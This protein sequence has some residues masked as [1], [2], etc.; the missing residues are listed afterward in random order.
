[1][2]SLPVKE[3]KSKDS[4]KDENKTDNEKEKEEQKGETKM[5]TEEGTVSEN[6]T[7]KKTKEKMEEKTT[8]EEEIK[9][10][11]EEEEEPPRILNG[12]MPDQISTLVR[13]GVYL[14]GLPVDPDA[15]HALLRLVLRLTRE[16][17]HAMTFAELGGV[18]LLLSLTQV[19]TFQ[20]FTSLVT[21]IIRH[22]LEDSSTMRMTLQK[23]SGKFKQ[24]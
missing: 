13:C 23:V 3:D 14:I 20:G 6:N 8:K 4:H 2:L 10:T 15:L 7:T 17:Q 24:T 9:E 1:M 21:L 16:H 12:L 11:K 22:I 18:K 5:D 19:S